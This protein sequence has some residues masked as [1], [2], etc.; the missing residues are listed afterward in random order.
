MARRNASS[1]FA[2]SPAPSFYSAN[3]DIANRLFF[4]LYQA[5]NLMHKEGTS[6]ISSFGTTTQQWAVL[7]A[8]LDHRSKHEDYLS[9]S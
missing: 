6:A 7:G 2:G 1:S 5:S 4:K 9:R 8:S 3:S